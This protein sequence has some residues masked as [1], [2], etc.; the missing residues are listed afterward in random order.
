M[1]H[2]KEPYLNQCVPV[3]RS[4]RRSECSGCVCHP[5]PQC[6]QLWTTKMVFVALLF[7]ALLLELNQPFLTEISDRDSGVDT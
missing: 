1:E 7:G 4:A 3:Q 5:D 6:S 2:V